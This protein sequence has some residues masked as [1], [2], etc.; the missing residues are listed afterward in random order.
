MVFM[1]KRHALPLLPCFK[2]LYFL[3]FKNPSCLRTHISEP[4]SFREMDHGSC[5][6][7]K[8]MNTPQTKSNN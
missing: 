4:V 1:T 5:I 3:Y 2:F 8:Y 7:E 6:K